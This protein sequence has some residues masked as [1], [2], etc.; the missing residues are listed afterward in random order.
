[1]MLTRIFGLFFAFL[2]VAITAMS[3]PAAVV[4]AEGE[5]GE[6]VAYSEELGAF[7]LTSEEQ[8]LMALLNAARAKAGQPALTAEHT[9]ASLAGTRSDDMATRQYFSH[10]TPE[11]TNVLQMLLDRGVNYQYAGET[12]QMNNY[13][14]RQTVAEAAQALLGSPAH[15]AIL[16]DGRFSHLGVGYAVNGDMHYYTVIVVQYF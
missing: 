1:M 16:L 14:P 9:L 11:G 10:T 3:A 8:Q 2:L 12:L 4:G 5:G 13:A 15:R 7:G 6:L